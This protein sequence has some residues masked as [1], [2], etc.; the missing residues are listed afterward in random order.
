M[1]IYTMTATFGKLENR[2]LTLQPGLNIIEAPNEWGKSTWCA[3]LTAMLYGIETRVHSTKAALADKERYAP[4]SG[5]PMSGRIDLCWNGRD[6]TIERSSKGRSLFGTFRAYETHTGLAV[7][8]LTAANCGQTLLGVEKNVFLRSGFLRLSDMPVTQDEALRRRL[9]AIVTTGDDSGTGDMLA[10]TL[11][12]LKNR[13]RANRSTGLLPQA[14]LQRDQIQ[15]KL[16]EAGH[17]R[18]QSQRQQQRL[19]QLQQWKLELENHLA[20]LHHA[21][22]LTYNEKLTAAEA[23]LEAVTARKDA[24]A[25]ACGELPSPEEVDARLLRLRQLRD[26]RDSLHMEM[27]L[28]PREPQKAESHPAFRGMRPKDALEQARQDETLYREKVPGFPW[29][30]L[31]LTLL[32]V[33]ALAVPHWLGAAVGAALLIAGSMLFC[34]ALVR[35]SRKIKVREALLAKYHPIL[36]EQWVAAAERFSDAQSTYESALNRH[37]EERHQLELRAQSLQV[38]IF[39]VTDGSSLSECERFCTDA[40]QKQQA[41]AAAIREYNRTAELVQTLRASRKDFPAPAFTD[42]LDYSEQETLRLLSDCDH[43][44]RQLQLQLGRT[45]GNLEALGQESA[46][47]QQLEA[48]T[49]RITKLETAYAALDLAQSTLADARAQLQRRFAPRISQRARDIFRQLTG[50]RYTRLQ[51]TDD[52]AAHAAAEDE[53]IL[54]SA[55]WRSEGTADQLYLSLRLAMAEALT[56]EAPLVL[57]DAL[58]RFDDT[59]LAAALSVLEEAS[60]TKQVILFTCQSRE[61]G[62]LQ[63]EENS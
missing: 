52:F 2:T 13:C 31:A 55:L 23:A 24:A 62:I 7:P 20:A 47:R 50:G 21:T 1:R 35:R 58:A 53:T 16:E 60:K 37:N 33:A 5:S 17:L 40:Q 42:K 49:E 15:K 6:I 48:V 46:L 41:Y 12:D 36:P 22:N 4:W 26:L 19:Q 14:E 32:S 61:T 28:Q 18:T 51:L 59:R 11:R 34:F 27:Q 39:S 57:D 29:H 44:Q 10:Q 30:W 3:F 45:Q 38:E 25:K 8:E 63:K 43:E 56:P 9:N 54:R